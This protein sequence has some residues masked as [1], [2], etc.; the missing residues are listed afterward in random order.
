MPARTSLSARSLDQHNAQ[1]VE[2]LEKAMALRPATIGDANARLA[3]FY[4]EQGNRKLAETF[5]K[6]AVEHHEKEE[7]LRE[8]AQDFSARDTFVPHEVSEV[9]LKEIQDQ[10]HKSGA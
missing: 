8:K 4:F 5:R 2:H 3:G 9:I 10:L 6:R 1:G 7:R